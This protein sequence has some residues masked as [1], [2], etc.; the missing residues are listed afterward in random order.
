MGWGETVPIGAHGADGPEEAVSGFEPGAADLPEHTDQLAERPERDCSG[1][2]QEGD[3]ERADEG[4]ACA[5]QVPGDDT[6]SCS[7][8]DD[9]EGRRD[10]RKEVGPE[11]RSLPH[12]EHAEGEE[13]ESHGPLGGADGVQI[14]DEVVTKAHGSIL[15]GDQIGEEGFV[16]LALEEAWQLPGDEGGERSGGIAL[17]IELM[18]QEGAEQHFAAGVA[19]A[20]LLGQARFECPA[21]FL[22]LS[23]AF[24]DRFAWHL[25]VPEAVPFTAP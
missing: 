25:L 2:E 10:A 1:D 23:Q 19:G 12:G 18:E 15:D 14:V 24:R 16:V 22:D 13:G 17:G 8:T 4:S 11:R 9:S 7:D 5:A 20:F 3:G 21:L 6:S